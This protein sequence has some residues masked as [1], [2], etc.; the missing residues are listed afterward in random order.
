[1]PVHISLSST[2]MAELERIELVRRVPEF[3]S[4]TR[5]RE[6]K[7]LNQRTRGSEGAVF[8]AEVTQIR[9]RRQVICKRLHSILLSELEPAAESLRAESHYIIEKFLKECVTLSKLKHRNCVKFLGV[10]VG[11]GGINKGDINLIMELL[12]FDLYQ[13]TITKPVIEHEFIR[14]IS[15]LRDVACGLEYLHKESIIHR[16]LTPRKS[17]VH[18]PHPARPRRRTYI[19]LPILRVKFRPVSFQVSLTFQI[20]FNEAGAGPKHTDISLYITACSV[21]SAC[22]FAQKH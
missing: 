21:R 2:A 9:P 1:M 19:V 18:G 7:L 20:F 8:I 10:N 14:K 22:S 3:K 13:V 16:D 4:L 17:A 6:V 11:Q 5:F 12:P 15:I